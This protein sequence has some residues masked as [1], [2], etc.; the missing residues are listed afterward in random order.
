MAG[1]A[2]T[3]RVPQVL[4]WSDAQKAGTESR[5]LGWT[6]IVLLVGPTHEQHELENWQLWSKLH[7]SDLVRHSHS[8]WP[9]MVGGNREGRRDRK[10]QEREEEE[11]RLIKFRTP[12]SGSILLPV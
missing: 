9:D 12:V 10:I 5:L 11:R 4:L 7:W 6:W 8:R 3:A 1:A 2:G